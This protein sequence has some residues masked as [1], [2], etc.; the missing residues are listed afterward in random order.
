MH[1]IWVSGDYGAQLY[2]ILVLR[3]GQ[4]ISSEVKESDRSV[5]IQ[6]V[7]NITSPLIRDITL[8]QIQVSQIMPRMN[9]VPRDQVTSLQTESIP[10]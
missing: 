3:R 7:H 10:G 4:I 6:S 1:Q 8:T 9:H 2:R 5:L